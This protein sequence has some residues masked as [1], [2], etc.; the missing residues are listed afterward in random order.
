MKAT[1]TKGK[2]G[3]KQKSAIKKIKLEAKPLSEQQIQDFVL[4]Y[5]QHGFFPGS[6]IPCTITGKLTTCMGP[7]MVK[8]VKEF[9]GPENLLRNY[10]CRGA[11]KQERQDKKPMKLRK[12]KEK[13]AIKQNQEGEYIVPKFREL[14]PVAIGDTDIAYL[15]QSQCLR[16]DL[17]L[18]NGRNCEGCSFYSTC[19][20][21]LKCLPKGV[22]FDGKNFVDSEEIKPKRKN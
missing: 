21:H 5:Q 17:F 13:V 2:R 22:I 15:T 14:K 6:K 3:R 20:L 19:T 1:K 10:R 7:W 16:P 12:R 8:K 11:L 4:F 18:G 9:G